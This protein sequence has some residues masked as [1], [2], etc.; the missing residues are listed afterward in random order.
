ME[1]PP[2]TAPVLYQGEVVYFFAFDAAYDTRR[3]PLRELLG[4]PVA[5]FHVDGS[6]RNPRQ[7]FFY[8]P[9]MV[10]LPPVER[11]GPQGAVVVSRAVKI[12]PV[13]AISI[14][15]KLPFHVNNVDD[16]VSFHDLRFGD[17][18]LLADEARHL[19]EQV[20]Q[21]LTDHFIRP[22]PNLKSEEAYTVFC[23]HAP[24]LDE[25]GQHISAENWLAKHRREVA[26]LLTE[27]RDSATLSE[28]EATESTARY[29]SYYERDLAVVDWDAALLIDEPRFLDQTL[30]LLELANLQLVELEAYD[31]ILDDAVERSYRDL[32]GRRWGFWKTSRTQAELREIRIDLARLSDELSNITK[33]FGDWHVARLYHGLADRFHLNDWHRAIDE[34]LKTMDDLYQLLRADQN[35]RWMFL[36]EASVILLFVIETVLLI[37]QMRR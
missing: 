18:A 6:K 26:S 13:G 32:L 30:Y 27:E 20:R 34:K 22:V 31:Q 28:Q 8:R 23:I 25:N 37:L 11:I 36:M 10:R 4:Q 9:E 14:M 1:S 12:L 24:L 29:Y 35:N 33:F 19:A 5:Q 15:I 17:G 2:V 16:L 3:T 21:E 7:V